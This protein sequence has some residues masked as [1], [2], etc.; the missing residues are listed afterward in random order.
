MGPAVRRAMVVEDE[1]LIARDIARILEN[2]GVR[3]VLRVPS[4]TTAHS[5]LTREEI[6]LAI[7]DIVLPD[8]T[9]FDIADRLLIAKIP[10]VFV[11]AYGKLMVPVRHCTAP[12]VHKPFLESKFRVAIAQA[13][14]AAQTRKN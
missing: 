12:F 7:L 4:R 9:V 6:E 14:S 11:S 1:A 5:F 8:G 2:V 10:Y 13:V 3:E